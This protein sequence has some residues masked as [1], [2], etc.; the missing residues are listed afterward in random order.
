MHNLSLKSLSSTRWEC[1]VDSV[2]AII[3]QTVDIRDALF[4]LSRISEDPKVSSEAESLATHELE[5]FEFLLAMTVWH[6]VLMKIQKV[7]EFL[8]SKNM[9]IDVAVQRLKVLI[10]YFE[11]YRN[12]G[13]SLAM[14]NAKKI[15]TNMEIEPIF[16]EKRL[17]H[18]KNNNLMKL[19]GKTPR[20]L[21]RN[22]LGFLIFWLLLMLLFLL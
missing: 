13:F 2:T 22:H 8:Q 5:N 14:D 15:A 11:N 20:F 9:Q 17:I 6:T 7:S 12:F 10:S 19:S 1:H 21:L 18:R 4:E 16:R 3:T